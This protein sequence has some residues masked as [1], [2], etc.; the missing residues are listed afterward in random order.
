MSSLKNRVQ[1]IG[2]VGQAPTITN[3]DDGKKVARFS[4][5]TNE[6]Y[7]DKKG[8]KHTDTNWH[9]IVAWGKNADF[10]ENYLKEGHF[11]ALTGKLK[12]GSYDT[13]NGEK[14]YY[15][16]VVANHFSFLSKNPKD[17]PSTE[18]E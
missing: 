13:D 1:L 9:T 6:G 7:K 8:E 10:V 16:E 17:T 18:E 14:K 3:L 2:N 15:T 12:S 4:F 11:V 5:A